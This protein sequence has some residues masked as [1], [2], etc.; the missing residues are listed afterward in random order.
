MV[1]QHLDEALAHHTR[2]AKNS[3]WNFAFHND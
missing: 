3:Y 2:R 1:F